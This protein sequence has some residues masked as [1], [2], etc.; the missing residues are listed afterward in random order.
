[1]IMSICICKLK[2]SICSIISD[3]I[4]DPSVIGSNADLGGPNSVAEVLERNRHPNN[5]EVAKEVKR[6]P[7]RHS[8]HFSDQEVDEVF[9]FFPSYG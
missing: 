2:M 4:N 5:V 7:A 8:K 3:F 9:N 6:K 1:M